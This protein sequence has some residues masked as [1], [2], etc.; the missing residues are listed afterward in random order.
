MK[1]TIFIKWKNIS[2][3]L[4]T[5]RFFF[6]NAVV[7]YGF[8]LPLP[9]RAT[10]MSD[11][12]P[13]LHELI[14]NFPSAK[15]MLYGTATGAQLAIAYALQ[16]PQQVKHVFLDNCAHFEDD[17]CEA[18]LKNYFPDFSPAT[19][20]SH[21]TRLWQYIC[22]SYLF[23]PW[24]DKREEN[25]IA[26]ELPPA[27]YIQKIVDDFILA[28]PNYADAYKA[29]FLHER[30]DRLAQLSVPSTLFRWAASPL[31][32]QMDRLLSHP[33]PKNIKVVDTPLP[34]AERFEVMRQTIVTFI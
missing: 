5:R 23:F 9:Q 22:D 28:G 21:L 16:H 27:T 34:M 7:G 3:R 10:A 29:A 8:S 24:Y 17:E 11:Y 20:G 1:L 18:I 25:R 2:A 30:A 19:D 33:L 13:F 12:V 31:Q 15:V 6:D 4:E 32:K 26:T 14:Q